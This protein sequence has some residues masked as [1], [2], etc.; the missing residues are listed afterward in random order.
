MDRRMDG[1]MDRQTDDAGKN[2]MSP[3]PNGRDIIID[4]EWKFKPLTSQMFSSNTALSKTDIILLIFSAYLSQRLSGEL[5][6]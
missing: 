6:G 1:R 2:I 5:I 4:I 3:N